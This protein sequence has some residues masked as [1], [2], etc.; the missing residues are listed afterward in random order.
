MTS[1]QFENLAKEITGLDIKIFLPVDPKCKYTNYNKFD[2]VLK[3]STKY[4]IYFDGSIQ[5]D[6]KTT[7]KTETFFKSFINQHISKYEL[8]IPKYDI[9]NGQVIEVYPKKQ[10]I[11]KKYTSNRVTKYHFYTTLY[12]IG[13]FA[14]FT[15]DIA[16]ATLEL[17]KYL[18]SKNIEYKNEYSDAGWVYRFVIN[19]DI[20]I[21]NNLLNN[22]KL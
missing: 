20:E 10:D 4:G 8:K 19:K 13:M 22:L 14:F 12:G 5:Y 3:N 17:T 18:K 7:K 21:H 11:I 9:L 15:K 2:G 1:I 16:L 6:F